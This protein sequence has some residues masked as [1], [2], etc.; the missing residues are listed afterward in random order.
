MSQENLASQL[1][2]S[3]QAIS[4]WEADD[5]TP[6]LT[7]LVAL[8]KIF[9]CSLDRLIFDSQVA[10]TGSSS[11]TSGNLSRQPK[12]MWESTGGIIVALGLIIWLII[13]T[14]F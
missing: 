1:H 13:D 3:R 12:Y 14:L 7:N 6:D 8:T 4:R 11:K 9:N 2:I 10:A 5:A